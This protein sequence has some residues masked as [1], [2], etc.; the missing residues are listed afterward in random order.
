MKCLLLLCI[1]RFEFHCLGSLILC[2]AVAGHLQ[3]AQIVANGL[4]E[5]VVKELCELYRVPAE[6]IGAVMRRGK[7]GTAPALELRDSVQLQSG[8][9]ITISGTN[10]RQLLAAGD[11]L[12]MVS[13]SQGVDLCL[14]WYGFS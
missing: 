7:G 6:S 11:K 4:C 10:S 2:C 1:C 13:V 12:T 3:L 8:D 5:D 14:C 9:I